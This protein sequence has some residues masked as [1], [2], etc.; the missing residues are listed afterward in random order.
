MCLLGAVMAILDTTVIG[1]AQRTFIARFESTQAVVGWTMAGYTL[2]LATVI[3]LAGWGADR[4]GAK[5]L[6][7]GSVLAFTAG[8]MLCATAPNIALLIAFRVVQGLGGGMLLPLAFTI[9]AREAGPKRVGRLMAV[10]GIP[11]MLCPM[12]GPILG[13]WIIDNYSWRWIFLINVP[14]G[15]TAF[16]L[17]VAVLP[18]SRA[19]R[20]EQFDVVGMLLLSPGLALLLY[21]ISSIALRGTVFDHHVWVPAAAGAALITA[22]VLHALRR[23]D[24]PLIDLRLFREREVTAAN[25][26]MLLSAAAFVGA[27]LLIPSCF[28]QLLHQTTLQSGVHMVPERL[29][30]MLSLPVAGAL[31]DRRGPRKIVLFGIALIAVGMAAF[32]YGVWTQAGYLPVLPAALALVGMGVG[33]TVMPLTAA[34]VQALAPQQIA[35]ASSLIHVN[36][37]VAGSL[38]TALMSVILTN[39]SSRSKDVAAANEITV[40]QQE[41]MRRGMAP[42]TSA[43]PRRAFAPDFAGN[44]LH[45]L[46]HAY[47]AVFV[48]A[49]VLALLALVPAVFLPN[50]PVS[51]ERAQIPA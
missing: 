21:G 16:V 9:L 26:A 1:V 24:H 43:M 18:R 14:I 2:A 15:V 13:G 45:D 17:A 40:L 37:Q 29:G 34:A 6:F 46:T 7:A 33:C 10:L 28:Q 47:T 5:R 39:Q 27:V 48:A 44:V 8:S 31:L 11:V 50:K 51:T 22:F 4:F 38:S 12:A 36:L 30:A 20:S 35:R 19:V 49:I 42:S 23:C 32:A 41:A 25:A 3:P